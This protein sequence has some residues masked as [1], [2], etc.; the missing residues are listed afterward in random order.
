MSK[1][2]K[3]GKK[4]MV[5]IELTPLQI[6]TIGNLVRDELNMVMSSSML[7]GGRDYLTELLA[8]RKI[9]GDVKL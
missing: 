8:I 2:R 4:T 6:V 3:S 1:S 9:L 7:P 5:N